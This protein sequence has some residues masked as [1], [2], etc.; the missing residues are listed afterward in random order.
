MKGMSGEGHRRAK[1]EKKN[2]EKKRRIQGRLR[3]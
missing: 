3:R 1:E 2:E